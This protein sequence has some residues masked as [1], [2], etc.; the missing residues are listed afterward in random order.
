LDQSKTANAHAFACVTA[1]SWWQVALVVSCRGVG[2]GVPCVENI[3]KLPAL[4][5][6]PPLRPASSPRETFSSML[7]QPFALTF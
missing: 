4:S 3:S 1:F 2:P 7:S 5:R 6:S